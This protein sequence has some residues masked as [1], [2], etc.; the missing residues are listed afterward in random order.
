MRMMTVTISDLQEKWNSIP[1]YSDGYI[2]V[3]GLSHPL[4]FHIGYYG[5]RK[6]FVVLDTGSDDR[7][8]SSKAITVESFEQSPGCLSLRFI[9]NYPSLED[10]FIKLCWDLIDASHSAPDPA[11]RILQQYNNWLRLLQQVNMRA[12]SISSQKGLC[13]ELLFLE[14]RIDAVGERAALDAW[15][16]PDGSDQDYIF[17]GFWAEVK[18]VSASA[19]SVR[20]SSLQQLDRTDKGYLV[21]YFLDTTTSHGMQ[22]TSLNDLVDSIR[23]RLGTGRER[24]CLDCKLA[25]YG[26]FDHDRDKYKDR[27]YRIGERRFFSV[28]EEFPKLVRSTVPSGVVSAKYELSIPAIGAFE[29]EGV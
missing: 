4:S 17:T 12:L 9:L 24:D 13:G 25:K 1:S 8:V 21:I 16:G 3:S 7:L 28:T 2:L 15:T 18:A 22:T 10:L 23:Q 20:I 11:E 19:D 29:S 27:R 14:D 5:G 6:C 26:Y